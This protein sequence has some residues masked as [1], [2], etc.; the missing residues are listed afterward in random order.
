MRDSVRPWLKPLTLSILGSEV[1]TALRIPA[2]ARSNALTILNFHRVDDNA[3]NADAAM[4]PA[5]FDEL[6][7]WLK[8]SFAIV[9]FG[10]LAANKFGGKPPMVISFDDGYKDFIDVVVPIAEKH[11]VRVNQNLIPA[12][13]DS[14]L[15]PM[16]VQL[17]DFIWTAPAALLRETPLPGLPRGA[18]PEARGKSGLQASKALKN[19]PIAVQK[20]LFPSLKM[21][22][23]RFDGF[24]PT[25][26]M[27]IEEARQIVAVHEVGAHSFEHATMAMETDAYLREDVDK[28]ISYFETQ[29][30]LRPS[31]YAL[32][33]GSARAGQPELIHAAGFQHVLL[34]GEGFS[35]RQNW[36][37][38]RFTMFAATTAEARFRA[39]GGFK[40]PFRNK[41]SEPREK[42][43]LRG[44]PLQS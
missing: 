23:Q 4:K 37:H 7:S 28:C 39:L 42:V 25:P 26:I 41:A 30:G 33:N 35:R 10:E 29:L 16:N 38:E 32:A 21:A 13:L 40:N 27:S 3:D 14:G 31:I 22:F 20:E 2:V 9:T 8:R 18:D 36:L 6:V 44:N 17:Q 15:P 19:R 34:T 5:L 1:A 24:R 11:R 12:A 43:A